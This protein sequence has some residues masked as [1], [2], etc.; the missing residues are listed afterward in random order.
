MNNICLKFSDDVAEIVKKRI[1]YTFQVYAAVQG[2]KYLEEPTSDSI[3]FYYAESTQPKLVNWVFLPA[4]YTIRPLGS[5]APVPTLT[6]AMGEQLYLFNGKD[7]ETD[8]PDFLG[9]IFEWISGSHEYSIKSRD[10]IGRI[11][12]NDLIFKK[13]QI[14][15][16]KP[17]AS[18]LMA[19]LNDYVSRIQPIKPTPCSDDH[20]HFVINTHDIDYYHDGFKKTFVRII[21]NLGIALIIHKDL[22]FFFQT[23]TLLLRLLC[24]FSV[25]SFL[26]A[27]I[28]ESEVF[29]FSSSL[30][31]ITCSNHRRDANYRLKYIVPHLKEAQENGFS[32]GLHGSY[33]SIV[34]K[35][36]LLSE[37]RELKRETGTVWGSRQHWLRFDRH[38]KLY[39]NIEQAE[40]PFDCTLGFSNEIGFR[41]GASFAFPPYNFKYERACKFLEFPLVIMEVSLLRNKKKDFHAYFTQI[42]E[43]LN[44]SRK[45][46]WGGVSV[47]WHY[48]V[49][50]LTCSKDLNRVFWEQL[51]QKDRHNEAWVSGEIFYK[52]ILP[53]YQ[54]AGLL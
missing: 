8:L 43:V 5:E 32:I 26:P 15:P 49:E 17:Y 52:M 37:A 38:Q 44:E 36:D 51:K 29:G 1:R 7:N 48:P 3:N 24:G 16:K 53:R 4:L 54:K 33:Q 31:I 23:F 34:E 12:Q 21:K 47:L 18:I 28:R 30:F 2:F 35:D 9:E 40:I 45:W 27:L 14:N 10:D 11:S 6:F 19:W 41:N 13:N 39:D 25:G 20:Q 42:D 50:S 46:G 22:S